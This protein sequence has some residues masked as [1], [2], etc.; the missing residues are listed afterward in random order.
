MIDSSDGAVDEE[1]RLCTNDRSTDEQ[2]GCHSG[3]A[4]CCDPCVMTLGSIAHLTLASRRPPLLHEPDMASGVGGWREG[5]GWRG[6]T[7][8]AP[9]ANEIEVCL[10]R[11]AGA[12]SFASTSHS[13]TCERSA[14]KGVEEGAQRREGPHHSPLLALEAKLCGQ[15]CFRSCYRPHTLSSTSCRHLCPR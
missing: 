15:P 6:R 2:W 4:G 9:A 7:R 14:R 12:L 13:H 8:V 10:C 1:G 3:E 5:R 11:V